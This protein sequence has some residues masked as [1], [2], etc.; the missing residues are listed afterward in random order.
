MTLNIQELEDYKYTR[1]F[2]DKKIDEFIEASDSEQLLFLIDNDIELGVFVLQHCPHGQVQHLLEKLEMLGHDKRVRYIA[3]QLGIIHSEAETNLDYLTTSVKEHVLQRIGWIVT[4]ALLGI[5]S[6]LIIA[7]YEDTLSTLV[8]LAVYMPVIAAAGGNTGSQAATLVIRALA[9][10]ELRKQQWMQV[11]YKE[12][13]VG[14]LIA[15][16]LALIMLHAYSFLVVKPAMQVLLSAI[17][18]WRSLS[19]YLFK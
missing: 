11:V 7:Q 14:I 2:Q 18:H 13:R 6:G 1:D 5:V 19:L 17:S 3:M 16:T 15:G 9:T 10:G 12:L 8:L 4:L